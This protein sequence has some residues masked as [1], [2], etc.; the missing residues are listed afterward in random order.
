M[1]PEA[2]IVVPAQAGMHLIRDD[3]AELARGVARKRGDEVASR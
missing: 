3:L 2:G 1:A